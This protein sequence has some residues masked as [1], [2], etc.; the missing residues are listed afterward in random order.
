MVEPVVDP[1]GVTEIWNDGPETGA[2]THW[3][4]HP[5]SQGAALTVKAGLV[6][7]PVDCMTGNSRPSGPVAAGAPATVVVVAPAAAVV[8]V[9]APP[10]EV[11]FVVDPTVVVVAPAA[12]VVVVPDDGGGSL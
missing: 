7:L 10:D 12:A 3:K 8:V 9:V 6:Q 5:M 11:V 4:A 2:G 1:A